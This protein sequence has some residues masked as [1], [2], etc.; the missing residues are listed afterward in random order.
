MA[1]ASTTEWAVFAGKGSLPETII[2][3]LGNPKVIC[4]EGEN[5]PNIKA[6]LTTRFGR[7]GQI[8][9]FL[10]ENG[11]KKIVFAGAMHRPDIKNLSP[12]AEGTKL[13]A[14]IMTATLF[15]GLGDDKLLSLI[16]KYLEEKGFEVVGAH[17]VVNDVLVQKGN[18]GQ[19][20]PNE[21]QLEDVRIAV[22]A[23]R[24]LGELDIG[25]AVIV[26]DGIV[27]A[28][29]A[30]EGTQRMIERAGL[31]KKSYGGVLVKISKPQQTDKAD[32]PTIGADTI[33]Q[34][35]AAG[36][37]GVAIESGNAIILDKE[38]LIKLADQAGVFVIGA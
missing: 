8:L 19:I 9:D 11:I 36:I 24:Q 29:E 20:I 32:L 22:K 12:D 14:R 7:I 37:A 18:Y 26:E 28:V 25:Q 1:A 33:R 15:G 10:Y 2:S 31:L 17:E 5:N 13:L 35:V 4:F 3:H 30:V 16:T 34:L 23:L 38:E 6:D 21:R 27:L